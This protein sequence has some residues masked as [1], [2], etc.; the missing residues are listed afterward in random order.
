MVMENA[1]RPRRGS[2][3]HYSS[4]RTST[5][6]YYP[7][8]EDSVAPY[9]SVAGPGPAGFADGGWTGHVRPPKKKKVRK[10]NVS[11]PKKED[12]PSS[13]LPSATRPKRNLAYYGITLRPTEGEVLDDLPPIL[14]DSDESSEDEF[15]EE[16]N[17]TFLNRTASVV[18]ATSGANQVSVMT[19]PAEAQPASEE[20]PASPKVTPTDTIMEE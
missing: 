7:V 19:E 12:T 5:M 11:A 4:S 8:T 17:R 14:T 10:P 1:T 9:P 15:A 6:D 20:N 2:A 18:N 16:V 3:F 13:S